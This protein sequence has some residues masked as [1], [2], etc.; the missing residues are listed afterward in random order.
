MIGHAIYALET[1]PSWSK[2]SRGASPAQHLAWSD[3]I[4]TRMR[5]N[6]VVD[7]SVLVGE[8]QTVIAVQDYQTHTSRLCATPDL[9]RSYGSLCHQRLSH[10]LD[11]GHGIGIR[12][13]P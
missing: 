13:S 9:S 1:I 3:E 11:N 2:N 8:L 7:V 12:S 6:N 10:L 5:D 4:I